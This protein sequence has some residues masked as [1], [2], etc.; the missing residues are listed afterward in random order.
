[1][2]L[3]VSGKNMDIGQALRETAEARIAEA[4][5]K[6]FDGGFSGHVTM[7]KEGAGFHTECVIHLDTGVE[8]Q[9]K[10]ESNDPHQ[11]FESAASRLEKRLRRYKRRLKGHNRREASSI[12]ATSYVI[13]PFHEEE[14]V[15]PDYAPTIVA[16]E[17]THLP[18]MSV[19]D[20][21]VELDLGETGAVV[22]RNAGH[23]GINVVYRRRDG[24]IGWIDPT[25]AN[26]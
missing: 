18:E 12:A 15:E 14:E 3:R 23:G 4:I 13:A 2:G 5:D 26:A 24:N 19:A 9:A 11:S 16:E 21:V 25:L 22:F 6:Y 10:G 7:A 8:L 20:A 1:M 17:A